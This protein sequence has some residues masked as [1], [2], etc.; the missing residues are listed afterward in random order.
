MT[1]GTKKRPDFTREIAWAYEALDLPIGEPLEVVSR[2]LTRYLEKCRPDVHY[3]NPEKFEAAL[4]LSRILTD[5]YYKIKSAWDRHQETGT[6][7]SPLPYSEELAQ[8][9]EALDLAFGQPLPE[10]NK[11]WR[12]YLQK[13]HPDRHFND[14]EK[15]ELANQL[16]RI[17]TDAHE[18]IRKAW[19]IYGRD[20]RS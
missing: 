9:Y 3:Q 19:E 16:T 18:K 2:R 7:D 14:P 17:L 5:A 20:G 1:D 10:V 11:Q 8:A 12:R 6:V 13:C 4:E 15:L